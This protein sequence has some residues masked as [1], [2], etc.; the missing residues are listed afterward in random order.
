MDAIIYPC[1]DKGAQDLSCVI[2]GVICTDG[3]FMQ[4]FI[5]LSVLLFMETRI[6]AKN[7]NIIKAQIYWGPFV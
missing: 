4:G 1:L 3:I 7:K 5:S 6:L 2:S